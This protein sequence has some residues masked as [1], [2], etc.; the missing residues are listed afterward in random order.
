MINILEKTDEIKKEGYSE[1]NAQAKL[2]QDIVLEALA[3]SDLNRSVTIK[4][5]VVM[6]SISG[7]IRRA[8]Q[9]MDIDFIRY[10]LDENAIRSFIERLN[11]IEGIAISVAGDIEKLKQQDYHG[12]KEYTYR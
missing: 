10:S 2:C 4:G 8:T 6:R 1:L 5:G 7:N 9:D 12:K 11:S 3:R